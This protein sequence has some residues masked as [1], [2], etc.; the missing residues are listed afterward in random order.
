MTW[1]KFAFALFMALIY[2]L[3]KLLVDGS[4][5]TLDWVS[6]IGILAAAAAAGLIP[7]TPWLNVAK[8]WAAGLVAGTDVLLVQLADGWQTNLDLWPTLIAVAQ[9]VGVWAV[10]NQNY[11]PLRGS[12]PAAR[13]A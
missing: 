4:M 6:L 1:N 12:L 8:L 3:Q 13:A 5:S 10:P 2:G 9:V 11:A 7:N